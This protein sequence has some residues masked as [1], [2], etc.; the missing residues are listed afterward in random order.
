MSIADYLGELEASIPQSP[1]IRARATTIRSFSDMHGRVELRLT[2]SD[3]SELHLAQVVN[4][5]EA[6]PIGKYGYHYQDAKGALIFRYDNK[7]HF[8]FPTFPNHKH[9]SDKVV[10]AQRPSVADVVAEALAYVVTGAQIGE[11]KSQA[12]SQETTNA[13]T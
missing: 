9:L 8:D 5:E 3:D 10:A 11:E 7:M 1:Q 2:F 4:L 12:R 13:Q 6:D